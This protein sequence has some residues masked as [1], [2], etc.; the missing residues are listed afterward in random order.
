TQDFCKEA[1]I[2]RHLHH[3]NIVPLI[4]VIISPGQCLLVS[5]WVDNGTINQFIKMN[6]DA[7][8]IDLL[9]DVVEGLMY[10]HNL[11]IVHGGLSMEKILITQSDHACLIGFGNAT[12][13]GSLRHLSLYD[14][15]GNSGLYG[16]GGQFWMIYRQDEIRVAGLTKE[17]DV[18]A[19]GLV[20]YEVLCGFTPIHDPRAWWDFLRKER[21]KPEDAAGLGF[22]DG[23]W[24]TLEQCWLVDPK[25][26]PT[27]REVLACLRKI[28]PS[29]GNRQAVV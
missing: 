25:K 6:P 4:G 2:W 8:R 21:A 12:T 26:R 14:V 15:I 13:A 20:I 3:P 29:W 16:Q 18:Y 24:E 1:V 22:T 23:L 28:A 7:N 9:I 5:D 27:L 19:L 17:L 11:S 10:M